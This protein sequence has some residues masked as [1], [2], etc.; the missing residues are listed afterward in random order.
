VSSLTEVRSPPFASPGLPASYMARG[1]LLVRSPS[2]RRTLSLSPTRRA[3]SLGPL[4]LRAPSPSAARPPSPARRAPSPAR[5]PTAREPPST[6]RSAL[7]ATGSAI[8]PPT[9][10]P[11]A[12]RGG[13]ALPRAPL[14]SAMKAPAPHRGSLSE[15][16]LRSETLGPPPP[17]PL[18]PP[19]ITA[20]GPS[21]EHALAL[22]LARSLERAQSD[23][24][25]SG[26]LGLGA[27]AAQPCATPLCRTPHVAV[28][29]SS[30]LCRHCSNR[31][32]A[33]SGG[34]L[35]QVDSFGDPVRT[36]VWAHRGGGGSW[37][38]ASELQSA[39]AEA[40]C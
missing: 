33:A 27:R 28:R 22:A 19:R 10:S 29:A 7:L 36:V 39:R 34:R 17:P 2:A 11:P 26:H 14:G 40:T 18:P 30:G 1:R 6:L 31:L 15:P 21:S 24:F 8:A 35:L 4:Q 20:A 16:R 3:A 5:L 9:S 12:S 13:A 23:A 32:A 38:Y 37:G 25:L